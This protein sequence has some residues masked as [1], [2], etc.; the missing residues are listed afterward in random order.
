MELCVG[1]LLHLV[2]LTER[3]VFWNCVTSS[4]TD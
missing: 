1:I 3:S 2:R 4:G